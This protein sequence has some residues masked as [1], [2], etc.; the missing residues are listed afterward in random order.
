M[1]INTASGSKL[2]IGTTTAA[3]NLSQ[4]LTDSYEEVG[5]IEDLGEFGDSAE[6][7][8][9]A[10][11]SD[12]RLRHLK[13]IRDAGTVAVIAGADASDLGQAAMVAA[14]ASVL[15][16]NF[17]I[18]LNDQLTISG[19]PSEHYFRGKV[20]SKRLGVGTANNVVRRTFNVGINTEILEVDPT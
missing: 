11:L 10:S 6:D 13:G 1:T 12:S 20:M 5:E 4:Y 9:F 19:T 3:E 2:F 8:T 7:V 18:V 17:K 16:F 14:E 15:D